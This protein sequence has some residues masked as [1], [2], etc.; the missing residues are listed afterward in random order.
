ME[1]EKW[2]RWIDLFDAVV[3]HT[4]TVYI[5]SI[6][7]ALISS[8]FALRVFQDAPQSISLLMASPPWD[9]PCSS[10]GPTMLPCVTRVDADARLCI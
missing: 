9:L 2:S 4:Y 10:F 7:I 3:H 6:C 8:S 5:V 1:N